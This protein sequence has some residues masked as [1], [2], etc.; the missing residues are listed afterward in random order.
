VI[1]FLFVYFFCLFQSLLLLSL[2]SYLPFFFPRHLLLLILLLLF[3]F[4]SNF[5][6]SLQYHYHAMVRVGSQGS[7]NP[8][9]LGDAGSGDVTSRTVNPK[10][11]LR[12]RWLA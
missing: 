10:P 2:L 12:N 4:F 6:L 7:L 9:E 3:I 11:T 8:D 5:F 1:P